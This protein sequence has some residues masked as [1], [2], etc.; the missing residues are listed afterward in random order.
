MLTVIVH[1]LVGPKRWCTYVHFSF[2]RR[3]MTS[4]K[5]IELIFSNLDVDKRGNSNTAEH[6]SNCSKK[7]FLFY[8]TAK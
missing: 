7:S 1:G 3:A 8:L 5:G 2:P 6:A 4:R